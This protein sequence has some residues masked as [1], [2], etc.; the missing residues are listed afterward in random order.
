MNAVLLQAI[1]FVP[2]RYRKT[3]ALALVA[4]AVALIGGFTGYHI[5]TYTVT[6]RDNAVSLAYWQLTQ[7]VENDDIDQAT[8]MFALISTRGTQQQTVH[9]A[10]SLAAEHFAHKQYEQAEQ[11]Y[12]LVVEIAAQSTLRDIAR[13]RL[14]KVQLTQG[15]I[16]ASRDTL[17]DVE[18]RIPQI[19][20][21]LNSVL[22]D[23]ALAE[24][25]LLSSQA[26]YRTALAAAQ[27][28]GDTSYS[29]LLQEKLALVHSLLLQETL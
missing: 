28:S 19:G 21:I 8:E 7:A 25:N 22:G 27:S 24:N 9:A 16:D 12:Q 26:S 1:S 2:A 18:Q 10:L 13:I 17:I 15:R 14:A 6:E 3:T 23:I 5:Y 20:I 11:L 4:V 29:N